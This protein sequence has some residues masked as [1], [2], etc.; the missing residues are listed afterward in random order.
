MPLEIKITVSVPDDLT[1]LRSR[2]W[3]R[4][5]FEEACKEHVE[6]VR[7]VLTVKRRRRAATPVAPP[8]PRN[9]PIKKGT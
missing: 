9:T 4:S 6:T 7:D 1:P 5:E 8:P 2:E 3:F